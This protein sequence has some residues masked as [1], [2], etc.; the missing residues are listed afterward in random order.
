MSGKRPPRVN[1]CGHPERKHEAGGMCRACYKKQPSQRNLDNSR[2]RERYAAR[3]ARGPSGKH[4][5]SPAPQIA[6]GLELRE[7][8][9]QIN[10]KGQ[11]LSRYDKTHRARE[12]MPFETVPDGFNVKEIVTR[13]DAD[14]RPGMQYVRAAADQAKRDAAMRAAWERHAAL[15]AGLALPVIAPAVTDADLITL[16]PLGDPHIG[17]LAWAP[18]TGDHFD[19]RIACRELLACVRLLVASAPPSEHAIV[20]NLGDFLHAQDD[21]QETPGHHHKLDVDDRYAKVLDAGHALLR[22]IVDAALERHA[23]V[24]VRNLPGNHDPRV[25]AE[26]AMWLRA[27]YENNPRVTV[28]D[29]YRAHQ[30]DEFGVNLFGWH[31]GDRTPGAEL[32]AIMAEDMREAWGRCTNCVWH[33]GHVHHLTR[34]ES[35]GCVVETHRTMAARDGYHAGRYRAGRSLSGITYHRAFAEHARST[36]NL[37]RVRAAL[38]GAA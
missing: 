4:A 2:A 6:T 33:C 34:K 20:C 19:T 23:R 26:L 25:A 1:E 15:Y 24:T 3:P 16:Y 27:V 29:P 11:L 17:M 7:Q 30:Y 9:T 35:P 13:V 8:T 14:G 28:A 5:E 18:E 21:S 36:V 32:P 10:A 37:A 38:A 12:P 31:H 22:G